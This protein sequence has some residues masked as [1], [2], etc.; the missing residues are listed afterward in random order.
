MPRAD[1]KVQLKAYRLPV[2]IRRRPM[3]AFVS[4]S[5]L[6]YGSFF[7]AILNGALVMAVA[8]I[9]L[10]A[11][12]T[13][14]SFTPLFWVLSQLLLLPA[15]M[16]FEEF[17]H[18]WVCLQKGLPHK[19]IDLVA[20][21]RMTA[22]GWKLICYG[23]AVRYRGR[24]TP[25]DRIHISAPGPLFCL[26]LAVALWSFVLLSSGSFVENLPQ[27]LFLPLTL[28]LLSS[29]WPHGAVLPT[30]LANVIRAKREG[31]Y[32]PMRTLGACLES[33]RLIWSSS[34]LILDKEES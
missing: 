13:Q 33:L 8:G 27:H 19:A 23:C 20:A 17:L 10:V 25:L 5:I 32:S 26:L 3:R 6:M 31:R 30:D 21:F 28:Y 12:W 29:L 2:E 1:R 34:L 16:A 9:L 18:L 24:L 11:G 15:L 14:G 4:L 7:G 22:E